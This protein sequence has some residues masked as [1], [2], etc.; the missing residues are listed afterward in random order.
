MSCSA[1]IALT[2]SS[3]VDRTSANGILVTGLYST[4]RPAIKTRGATSIASVLCL[5][6]TTSSA[7]SAFKNLG[8]L[9]EDTF[10]IAGLGFLVK[11]E[12]VSIFRPSFSATGFKLSGCS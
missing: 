3:I 10:D 4:T 1:S 7:N 5:F 11:P 12:T 2:L 6:C 9:Y 8:W